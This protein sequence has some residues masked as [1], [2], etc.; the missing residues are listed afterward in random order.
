MTAPFPPQAQQQSAPLY[1]HQQPQH[2]Q[3]HLP[4][5]PMPSQHQQPYQQQ[6]FQTAAPMV[7]QHMHPQQQQQPQQQLPPHMQQQH[8]PSLVNPIPLSVSTTDAASVHD[9]VRPPVPSENIDPAY[10][11]CTMGKIPRTSALLGKSRIPFGL[12]VTP[13]P[14]AIHG[15]LEP[16]PLINGV[17]VRCRRCRTYLNPFVEQR[18]Q[19][20]RWVCNLCYVVNECTVDALFTTNPPPARTHYHHKSVSVDPANFDYDPQT[21]RMVDRSTRPELRSMVYEFIAPMEYMV[22]APQPPSIVFLL[23]VTLGALNSGT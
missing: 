21:Q 5:V 14:T 17:I 12:T 16:V 11:R 1:Q 13:Y 6:Q 7:Q 15:P 22:R 9:F 23:D 18:D 4:Q 3:Q 10:M 20:S 2:I 19:A 8:R